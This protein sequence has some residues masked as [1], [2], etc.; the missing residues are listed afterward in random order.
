MGE[1]HFKILKAEILQELETLK[2][3]TEDCIIFYKE[4]KNNLDS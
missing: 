2:Q 4:N 1:N 3:L